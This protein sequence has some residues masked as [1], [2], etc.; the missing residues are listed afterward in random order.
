MQD[1]V[2]LLHL[3][4]RSAVSQHPSLKRMIDNSNSVLYSRQN[5]P[6]GSDSLIYGGTACSIALTDG[7][8]AR[9]GHINDYL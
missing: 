3:I 7:G 2:L 1:K 4:G 5:L 8:P 9:G 6:L